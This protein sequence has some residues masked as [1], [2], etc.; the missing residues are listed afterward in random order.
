MRLILLSFLLAV[1]FVSCKKDDPLSYSGLPGHIDFPECYDKKIP[2]KPDYPTGWDITGKGLIYR[3]PCF[4]PNNSDEFIYCISQFGATELISYNRVTGKKTILLQDNILS[5]PFWGAN[6]WIIMNIGATVWKI[7]E[8]GD[9]LTQLTFT[10]AQY[11]PNWNF[12]YSKYITHNN[13]GGIIHDFNTGAIELFQYNFPSGATWLNKNNFL[14]FFQRPGEFRKF[15]GGYTVINMSSKT[16][17]YYVVKE[18]YA[19][20]SG[21]IWFNEDIFLFNSQHLLCTFDIRTSEIREIGKT[22]DNEFLTLGS[23]AP[24]TN[25][26]IYEVSH[27]NYVCNNELEVTMRFV[28]LNLIDGSVEDLTP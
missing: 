22:C 24:S 7:K 8:N 15:Y 1:C 27:Y 18:K 10:E 12:D 25:E 4:N 16:H 9:S 5:P 20:G 26:V 19:E 23:F 28:I 21:G 6:G 13:K 14:V 2:K 3:Y 11:Y 17:I